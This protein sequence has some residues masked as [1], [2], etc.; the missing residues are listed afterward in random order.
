LQQAV[1]VKKG[2][3]DEELALKILQYFCKGHRINMDMIS[4]P[5]GSKINQCKTN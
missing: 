4:E 2:T 3:K 5:S 1:K